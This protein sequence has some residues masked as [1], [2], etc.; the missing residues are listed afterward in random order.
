MPKEHNQSIDINK[1]KVRP[2]Y[3]YYD[4]A[5]VSTVLS[6]CHPL[7][8][9]KAI[10]KRISYV[11]SYQGEWV[12]VAMFDKAVDRNKHREKQIGWSK[13][14]QKERIKHIANNSRFA[15]IPKYAGTQNLASKILSLISDRISQDWLKQYGVPLLALETYVDPEY[16]QNEGTCYKAAGW[17]NLGLSSGYETEDGERTHGKWYFLKS[18]HKDSYQALAADLPNALLTGIKP[19]SGVSNNN[20]V[21]DAS[22]IDLSEL[23]KELVTITDP[24]SAHGLRY[25]CIPFLSLC[26]SAVVSGYTQ[27]RQIA[28]WISKIPTEERVR[29]GMPAEETPCESMVSIFLRRLDPVQLNTVL[30]KWLLKTYDQKK[31][32]TVSLDGKLLRATS[33][34][35]KEQLAFLNVYAH[36]LGIVIAQLPTKKGGG[37]KAQAREVLENDKLLEGKTILADALHTDQRLVELLEKKTAITCSRSK[38]IKAIS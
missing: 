3:D 17:I 25:P 36:E 37:E 4:R 19:V 23:Q 28:G 34:D 12:A 33:S 1:I 14:Q 18:L 16:H 10:G 6:R 31:I 20:Y 32:K 30:T 35:A 11:A 13:S 26:I 8:E 24:R 38:V 2:A 5:D 29:F 7:G 22:K 21:L 15:V 9:K 27:Y